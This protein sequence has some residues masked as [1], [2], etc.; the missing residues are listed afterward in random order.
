MKPILC[1]TKVVQ[2][3]QAGIQTQDRRP[4]P[5]KVM[6]DMRIAQHVGEVSDFYDSGYLQVN[7]ESYIVDFAKYQ[8]G[9]ILYVRETWTHASMYWDGPPRD[10]PEDAYIW[11]RADS[12]DTPNWT[13]WRPNIH[14]PKWAARIFLKVTGVRVERIQDISHDDAIA[15]GVDTEGL[16][17]C[18]PEDFQDFVRFCGN[19]G[20]RAVDLAE[21]FKW[22]IWNP[23]YPG[24][25]ERNDW[26]FV[27]DFKK[28]KKPA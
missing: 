12:G 6:A 24:S 13:D 10:I 20:E 9:D 7:D 8:V 22:N 11:Y 18:K 28:I 27:Y 5:K 3:I 21:E 25:W 15:E 4:I 1:N 14:M 17:V 19:C 23:I 2:N 16:C 26:V